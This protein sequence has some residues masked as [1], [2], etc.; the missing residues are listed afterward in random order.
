MTVFVIISI[1][2]KREASSMATINY[3]ERHLKTYK[4]TSHKHSYWEIIYVTEGSGQI[5]TEDNQV[6]PYAQGDTI[7]IPPSLTN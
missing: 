1:Q 7:C 2:T 6:F 4:V 5:I 3:L